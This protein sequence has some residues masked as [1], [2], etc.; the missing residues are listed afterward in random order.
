MLNKNLLSFLITSLFTIP[1]SAALY[2]RGN[3]MIY[4]DVLDITWLQDANY[5]QTSGYAVANAVG[6]VNTGSTNIQADGRMGWDAARAWADQLNFGGYSDWGLGSFEGN[7]VAAYVSTGE[8]GH[9]FYNNLEGQSQ[10][11]TNCAFT[12]GCLADTIYYDNNSGTTVHLNVQ[13][14]DY[15]YDESYFSASAWAFRMS[16]GFQTVYDISYQKYAWAVADGDIVTLGLTSV[17][18]VPA[19]AWLF[20]SA[21]IGLVG[22]K[23]KK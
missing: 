4:D 23:R 10:E 5:A 13:I 7:G 20:G 19:S 2:D 16:S 22:V 15:W 1:V 8:L 6:G 12:T 18:P 21:L 14:G 17:V 11:D 9:M 3:G